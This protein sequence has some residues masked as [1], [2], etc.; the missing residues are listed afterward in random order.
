MERSDLSGRGSKDLGNTGIHASEPTS[1]TIK[2]QI[3]ALTR[4][5]QSL[6]DTREQLLELNRHLQRRLT[7]LEEEIAQDEVNLDIAARG[8]WLEMEMLEARA[9]KA[10]ESL[11]KE[12]ETLATQA[13]E[14]ADEEFKKIVL[15]G[16]QDN[17]TS[18]QYVVEL[19]EKNARIAQL[20]MQLAHL[21]AS[22]PSTSHTHQ[23]KLS[24][25]TH[26]AAATPPPV[27]R[28]PAASS[29]LTALTIETRSSSQLRLATHM[30]VPASSQPERCKGSADTSSQPDPLPGESIEA[31]LKQ[32]QQR[33]RE[34][35]HPLLINDTISSV[36]QCAQGSALGVQR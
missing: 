5:N 23:T 8:M 20:E 19:Q 27:L 28:T 3:E 2:M 17:I 4:E 15:R 10:E 22:Q 6:L 1:E 32:K 30:A 12:R 11:K 24:N 33:Q 35:G 21:Q 18:E 13:L 25:E 14:A 36:K 9:I 31:L 26:T 7:E 34:R 29:E 16:E